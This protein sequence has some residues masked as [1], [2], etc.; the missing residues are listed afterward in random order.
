MERNIPKTEGG[1][2]A[3][4]DKAS[5]RKQMKQARA[6]LSCEERQREEIACQIH[7]RE[8]E[9]YRQNRWIYLYLSYNHEVDTLHLLKLLW[10]DGKR[11]AVPK[12][13]GK[14]MQ[15]WEICSFEECAPGTYG[16]LEP[17]KSGEPVTE[18]GLMLLPGLA[19]DK[20]GG[21]LG[22][23]GGFYDRYLS[24]HDGIVTVALAYECQMVEAVPAEKHDRKV[25]YV[26]TRKGIFAAEK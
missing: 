14:D 20:K 25:D 1:A 16:I 13:S 9:L 7:L 21:R 8:S 24:V 19:F 22:Y 26:L 3:C 12:V 2:P 10:E 23:G 4:I 15:F 18:P 5:L 6:A 11:V 17:E